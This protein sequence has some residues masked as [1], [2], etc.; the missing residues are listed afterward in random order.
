MTRSQLWM[1]LRAQDLE[2]VHSRIVSL[3]SLRLERF[4]GH[5][6]RLC[7]RQ[8]GISELNPAVFHQL[9][10]LEELDLYDNKI[11]ALGTALT[12]MTKLT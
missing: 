9:V 2:L 1:F 11:K 4:A 6:K 5:L 3:N 12:E 7:L 10:K 8:N